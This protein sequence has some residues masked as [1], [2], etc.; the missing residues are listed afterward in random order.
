[1]EQLRIAFRHRP[2][3]QVA[4]LDAEN[5]E[6]YFPFE[7]RLDTVICLNVLEHIQDDQGTLA[8][9][10]TVLQPGGRLILL[11]PNDPKSYGTLDEALGHHRRYTPALLTQRVT[12][13]GFE[14][15]QMLEFNRVSL[16][17]WRF[18]GKVLKSRT[19]SPTGMKLFDRF[20]WLWRRI[21]AKLPW[22]PTSII[23]IVRR[24]D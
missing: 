15:E 1:V 23:A 11:V 12:E 21:D 22:Q 7:N 8:R 20:V 2:I 18:T 14:L 4:R 6:D 19:L 9:I 5:P 16:P 24:R 10:R 3:V 13:A 17:A